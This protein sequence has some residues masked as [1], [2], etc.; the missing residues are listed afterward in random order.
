MRFLF[1]VQN[2]AFDRVMFLVWDMVSVLDMVFTSGLTQEIRLGFDLSLGY[3]LGLNKVFILGL[4][5]GI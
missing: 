3:S 4:G 5:Q 1:R 2:Q